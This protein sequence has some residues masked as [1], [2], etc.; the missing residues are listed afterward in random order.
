VLPA[1]AGR[2]VGRCLVEHF[3]RAARDRGAVT[4]LLTTDSEGND[5]VNRF[6]RRLGFALAG[7][8]ETESGRKLN[9]YELKTSG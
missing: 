2:G 8:L 6:Y 7:V 3:V 9:R 1:A 4:V 5:A